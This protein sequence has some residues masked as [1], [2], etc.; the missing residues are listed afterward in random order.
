AARHHGV[1]RRVLGGHDD[2]ARR[3]GAEHRVGF[4]PGG[5]KEPLDCL[6]G[7]GHHRQPVGPPAPVVVL[8]QLE[9]VVVLEP[10]RP[11]DA[12]PSSLGS[13]TTT[14]ASPGTRRV[15]ASLI[16]V[17]SSSG[18]RTHSRHDTL[19][20][21]SLRTTWPTASSTP[22]STRSAPSA[23]T[24]GRTSSRALSTSARAITAPS[25]RSGMPSDVAAL[26]ARVDELVRRVA[27]LEDERAIIDV[28]TR[29]GF[30][31]DSGLPHAT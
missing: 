1:D 21:S 15:N 2:L 30:A 6:G 16:M 19:A 27:A 7:R 3:D 18:G 23:W 11:K 26:E 14:P 9:R 12:H 17:C 25:I 22:W 5:I 29:Y 31:V 20:R 8:D 24:S 13:S 10:V 28:L 4:E